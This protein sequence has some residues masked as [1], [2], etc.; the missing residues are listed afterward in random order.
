MQKIISPFII[1]FLLGCTTSPK[2]FL[3][4]KYPE[5]ML[6][7]DFGILSEEDLKHYYNNG[8]PH[9]L[10]E[11]FSNFGYWICAPISQVN[12]S[13]D[14]FGKNEDDG[15][16]YGEAE[17]KI[18]ADIA[19]Y[20]FGGRHALPIE[21]CWGRVQDWKKLTRHQSHVCV[22]GYEAGPKMEEKVP[23]YGFV[24]DRIKTKSGCDDW[25]DQNC[26]NDLE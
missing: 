16:H 23:V 25:F 6:T 12:F 11:R 8:D 15:E 13:C 1:I 9:R 19:R 22:S 14:D 4:K 24:Y 5:G 10:G 26:K 21:G 2:T 7:Q 17:I 20:E 3:Q 18:R